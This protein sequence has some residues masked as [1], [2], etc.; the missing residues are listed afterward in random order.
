MHA[1][2]NKWRRASD[3]AADRL[4]RMGMGGEGGMGGGRSRLNP[5][6][7]QGVQKVGRCRYNVAAYGQRMGKKE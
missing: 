5:E 3:V 7:G 6:E 2:I 1:G 4:S